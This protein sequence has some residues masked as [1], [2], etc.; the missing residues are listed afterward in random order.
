[1]TEESPQVE[2]IEQELRDFVAAHF[3]EL[4]T[5]NVG[6]LDRAHILPVA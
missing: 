1:M 4:D 3:S 6:Y 2:N 5:D